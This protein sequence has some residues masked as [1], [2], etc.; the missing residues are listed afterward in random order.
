MLPEPA[1]KCRPLARRVVAAIR[2][3]ADQRLKARAASTVTASKTSVRIWDLPT[4][5]THW[6]IVALVMFSW[7]SANTGHLPWHRLSGD[8]I[9]SLILFRLTW[10]MIGSQT[11]R[12]SAFVRGPAAIMR[13]V[14]GG[15]FAG[16]GHN[17]LGALSVIALL[18]ALCLQVGLGLF[19][20]D[21]DGLEPG[22]LAKYIDFDT[23]R[24]IAKLHH[25]AFNLLLALVVIHLMAIAFHEFRRE[26]LIAP[27]IT[28]RGTTAD[29]ASTPRFSPAWLA[30]VVAAGAAAVAWFVA[31]GLKLSGPI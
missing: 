21:E 26:R 23:G 11:A 28:G 19:A 29:P 15:T 18:A 9:L 8:L 25:L 24:A 27:M 30:V 2:S 5:L 3:T 12:F 6:A 13:Y 10:G 20:V 16:P 31:H 14:G 22:P 17:P 7:W 4:R 1:L